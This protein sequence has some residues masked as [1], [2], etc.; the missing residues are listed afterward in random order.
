MKK[1]LIATV[2]LLLFISGISLEPALPWKIKPNE[3]YVNFSCKSAFTRVHGKIPDITG[4]IKFSENDLKN[5][6]FTAT[7]ETAKLDTDNGKR[8]RHLKSA[9][10]LEVEKYPQI[11]F[12]S[13]RVDKTESGY[14]IT[15]DLTIKDVTK[16]ISFPFTFENQGNRAI[17][18]GSFSFNR[19]D[20]HVGGKTKLAKDKVDV[21]IVAVGEEVRLSIE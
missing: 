1:L 14:S 3:S 13:K 18:R 11:K 9:D 19:R 8:D 12:I 10:F 7:I 17:F 16:E 5:S 6:K 20:Y 21:D 15:G 4:E 2:T